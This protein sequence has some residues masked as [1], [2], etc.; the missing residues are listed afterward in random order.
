[1]FYHPCL[2]KFS[3]SRVYICLRLSK[4]LLCLEGLGEC[5]GCARYCPKIP[6]N[7][8]LLNRLEGSGVEPI[9]GF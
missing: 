6:M 7:L 5:R 1:M 4:P 2:G 8:V 3:Q 9:P